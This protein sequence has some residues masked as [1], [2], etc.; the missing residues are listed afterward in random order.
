MAKNQNQKLKLPTLY[1][2]LLRHSDAEHPLSMREI[3]RLL[4]EAGIQA[5]RKSIYDDLLAL[6]ALGV[7]VEKTADGY[8]LD[9]RLFDMP[10]LKLLIDALSAA[11]FVTKE[12]SRALIGKL[13]STVSE[14]EARTLARQTYVSDRAKTENGAVF[15]AID[16]IHNAI[17]ENRKIRFR[18][19]HTSPERKREFHNGGE[20]YTVSPFAL[21]WSDENYYLIAYSEQ[22]NAIRHYRVDRMTAT[23]MT[24]LCREGEQAFRAFD[25]AS[26]AK[27]LFGMFAGRTEAVTL[28]CDDRLADVIFDRFGEDARPI[29]MKNGRFRVTVNVIPSPHFLAYTLAFDGGIRV[30]SPENVRNSVRELLEKHTAFYKEDREARP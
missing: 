23:H 22:R 28:E 8:Y 10:E 7:V 9:T 26:Y 20:Y 12:K 3:L 19:F 6:D 18:Y 1:R 29:P 4:E 24:D 15:S 21:A 11:R 5:E 27:S 25:M 17:A 14:Y 13:E 2:I 30:I 16:V